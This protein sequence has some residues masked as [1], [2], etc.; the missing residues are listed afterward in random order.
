M[1]DLLFV[2]YCIVTSSRCFSLIFILIVL[3]Q[4]FCSVFKDY[5]YVWLVHYTVFSVL[6]VDVSSF[7]LL[8]KM[9]LSHKN[10]SAMSQYWTERKYRVP[11]CASPTIHPEIKFKIKLSSYTHP[12]SFPMCCRKEPCITVILDFCRFILPF[13]HHFATCLCGF[14]YICIFYFVLFI[15]YFVLFLLFENKVIK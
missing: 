3:Y 13:N 5:S 15:V 12:Q 1:K 14:I 2:F 7:I 10:I 6:L 8:M 4:C 11:F 9:R